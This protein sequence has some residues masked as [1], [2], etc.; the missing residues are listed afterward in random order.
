[1]SSTTK[2]M[3]PTSTRPRRRTKAVT[4]AR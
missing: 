3:P 1:L 4:A 2:R